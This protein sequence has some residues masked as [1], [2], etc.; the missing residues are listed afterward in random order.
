[1]T[2]AGIIAQL[3]YGE[4]WVPSVLGVRGLELTLEC[5]APAAGTEQ[6]VQRARELA[7][8]RRAILAHLERAIAYQVEEALPFDEPRTEDGQQDGNLRPAWRWAYTQGWDSYRFND[9]RYAVFDR[10]GRPL[11]PQVCIDFITDT[12][13]RASGTWWAALG[14]ERL[15]TAGKL[16]FDQMDLENRRSVNTFVDFAERH[17]EWFDVYHLRPDERV[18]LYQKQR[19]YEHLFAN[20]DRYVPGDIVTIHGKRSDDELHYHSF[21]VYDADP[22]TGMPMLV[23][24][25]AGKPRV[26]SWESEMLSA[27]RRSIRSRV[28]PRLEWLESVIDRAVDVSLAPKAPLISA[29]G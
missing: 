21:F 29:P 14:P 20:R 26:R 1:M 15:K 23:A 24:A 16:D 10:H 17:P 27:P 25:N 11:V 12:L 28:R 6:L 5:E 13:E 19:F 8:R 2:A 22:V 3:R 9:E 18:P 7:L 4:M